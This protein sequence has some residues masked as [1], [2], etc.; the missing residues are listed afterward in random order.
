L[1]EDLLISSQ[2]S[3][4]TFPLNH[5]LRFPSL[6]A[7]VLATKSHLRQSIREAASNN[8][9]TQLRHFLNTTFAQ[10]IHDVDDLW[11]CHRDQVWGSGGLSR[12]EG[13]PQRL[14]GEWPIRGGSYKWFGW[15]IIEN[16]YGGL[17]SRLASLQ[18]RLMIWCDSIDES[19]TA[20]V[21]QLLPEFI[22]NL[23]TIYEGAGVSLVIDY[24]R[25][26]TPC[27]GMGTG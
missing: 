18:T 10:L 13:T 20:D 25:A 21:S 5:H 17:R 14:D 8:E 3:L 7:K 23:E 24:A 1:A 22:V 11:I 16:R 4:S 26:V 27:R 6:L 12:K 2:K 19:G 15:E 9:S